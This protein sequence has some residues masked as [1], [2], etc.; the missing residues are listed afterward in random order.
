MHC[1]S[2]CRPNG[3]AVTEQAVYG[4]TA[5]AL[6]ASLRGVPV[7]IANAIRALRAPPEPSS[8]LFQRTAS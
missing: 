3:P 1:Q 5:A 7:Q 2:N 6:P 4:A 8:E